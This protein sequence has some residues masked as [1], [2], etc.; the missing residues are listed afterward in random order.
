[1]GWRPADFYNS[2][3][4]EISDAVEGWS[5]QRQEDW[6]W[7]RYNTREMVFYFIKPYL[8]KGSPVRRP[9]D[10]YGLELDDTI[11]RARHKRMPR[12]TIIKPEE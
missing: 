3:L 12:A 7:T 10:L 5:R 8:P 11:T 9:E 2:T 1:M 4:A 6:M